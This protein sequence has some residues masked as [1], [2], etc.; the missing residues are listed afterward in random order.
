M[1]RNYRNVLVKEAT[2][3]ELLFELLKR[4]GVQKAPVKIEFGS[5]HNVST[6][7][8]GNDHIADIY[9]D[10]DDLKV[11]DTMIAESNFL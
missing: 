7:G 5:E 3:E 9:V 1:T 8:I 4:N 6:I 11:L 10:V 2:S